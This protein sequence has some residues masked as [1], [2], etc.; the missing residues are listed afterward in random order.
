[1]GA[2][3]IFLG[4]TG[5][6]I[7][8]DIQSA[9]DFYQDQSIGDPV[10]FDLDPSISPGVQL[11]GFVTADKQTI[12]GVKGLAHEW[13]SREPGRALG[14]AEGSGEPGP[15]IAP[16]QA[17]LARIGAGIAAKP[18]PTRGLFALRAHGLAVFS[19]LFDDRHALAGA[20]PG[21]E[22]RQHIAERMRD[23]TRDGT[24]PRIN[25]VTSTAGGTGAGMVIPLALWLREEYPNSLLNLV[26]VTASAFAGVLRGAP[27]LE[28]TRAKG[29]SGTYALLRE[30]SWFG[31]V[32][33]QTEFPERRL[34]VTRQGLAYRPGGKLFDHIYWFGGRD[35]GSRDDAFREAEP[36]LRVLSAD[37]PADELGG[38]T[39]GSPLRWVG[40]ATA[41]EYPKLRLQRRMVYGVLEDAYRSLREPS[42][43]FAGAS[44]AGDE[45]S[46][47][48]YVG[49]DTD[50]PL[51]AWLHGQRD[52]LSSGLALTQGDAD[53]LVAAVQSRAGMHGYDIPRGTDAGRDPY[54]SND[55]GWQ[56]YVAR[57]VTRLKERAGE[58]ERRLGGA[59]AA[60]RREEEDAFGAWLRDTAYGEWLSA[61]GG[62]E[63]RATGEALGMLA[64]LERGA[65]ELALRFGDDELFPGGTVGDAED[66]IRQREEKFEKPDPRNADAAMLDKV[67]SYVVA[68]A[69]GIVGWV[70]ARPIAEAVPEFAGGLSQLLPWIG[71][72]LAMIGA[73]QLTLAWRL[74]G[75]V[76]WATEARARQDAE[77]ALIAAY[78]DRDRVRALHWLQQEMRGEGAQKRDPFFEALRQRITS[79]QAE[80]QRLDEIYKGLQDRA[81]AEVRGGGERPAH[82]REEVGDCLADDPRMTERIRPQVRQRIA[83]EPAG[84]GLRLLLRHAGRS[85]DGRFDPAGEDAVDLH[86]ALTAVDKAGLVDAARALEH[87]ENAAWGLV[88]WQLGEHL[89]PDFDKAMLRCSNDDAATAL[90]SLTS[91]LRNLE[92]PKAPSVALV[93]GAGVP[94]HRRVYASSNAVLARLNEALNDSSLVGAPKA[95]LAEYQK[96]PMRVVPA[97]GEQIVFLDLWADPGDV[98]WAPH[99]IGN[100]VEAR[101]AQETY[102]SVAGTA[103][104]TTAASATFTVIPE[105][106][107]A[108]KIEMGRGTVEPLAPAV[109][110]RLLG[111]DLDMQGPTYAELFYLLRH[112]G[113]LRSHDEGA[114]PGAS[115]VTVIGDGDDS[116]AMPLVS[117][118]RGGIG[119]DR[120][121]FGAGRAAVIDFDTFVEFMRYDGRTLMAGADVGFRPFP[122]AEPQVRAWAAAPARVAALQRMAVEEWYGGD[123]D[124]DAEAMLAVLESDLVAMA[125]G[126]AAVRSS[127]ERAM[128][129]LLAGEERK[130]IRR[131]HLSAGAG[132]GAAGEPLRPF[133][134]TGA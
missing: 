79:A 90:R 131:T 94:E 14:P 118:P 63:P 21:N 11:R 62:G 117:R 45:V 18:A 102:Y 53:A 67:L 85:D 36:L 120:A 55:M 92:L 114:G 52:A 8:E 34:P 129:R 32:D 127:W 103:P 77:R 4:G 91:K 30:L 27:G 89:P 61:S 111:C 130:A 44:S 2:V 110:A 66:A 6:F 96:N 12:D 69:V 68:A 98:D 119:E 121:A 72:V 105:L 124:G 46:L 26:A 132:G 108:T 83:V 93:S 40:A 9:R 70:V 10:A 128:R 106:L 35:G 24:A 113:L 49:A 87:W 39:G 25:I 56:R 19:M 116:D 13:A 86:Q 15:R 126:D 58:E 22:L 74:R 115:T 17:P 80:V 82:V 41:I 109:V 64:A 101:Q 123:A 133:D 100:A 28:E 50:R 76:E 107:A 5:K 104:D 43:R 38:A 60:L 29:L 78:R 112:R 73:R 71:V 81:A 23:E 75:R 42:G 95:T 134:A 47:L 7:A 65:D 33:P 20:G 3:N 84:A 122:N 125:N 59:I 57:I 31:E 1:M 51:G 48:D 37:Q 97:L 99:V 16:E 88:N 54:G